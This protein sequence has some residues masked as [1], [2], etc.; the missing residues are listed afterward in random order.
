MDFALVEAAAPRNVPDGVRQRRGGAGGAAAAV[1]LCPRHRPRSA[2]GVAKAGRGLC[3]RMRIEQPAAVGVRG[4][5]GVSRGRHD[6]RAVLGPAA[7]GTGEAQKMVVVGQ[8]QVR[9]GALQALGL[10]GGRDPRA[11]LIGEGLAV[12][13]VQR[14]LQINAED[15]RA[16]LSL[17]KNEGKGT[18]GLAKEAT[19]FK[20]LHYDGAE[21]K[22]KKLGIRFQGLKASQHDR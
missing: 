18:G 10:E 4:Q 20:G 17:K 11:A 16:I 21:Q 9:A 5:G 12:S 1:G 15:R 7:E 19:T 14:H 3:L 2:H 8:P 22:G 13:G 6:V